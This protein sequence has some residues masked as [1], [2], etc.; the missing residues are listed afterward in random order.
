MTEHSFMLSLNN[1]R[2]QIQYIPLKRIFKV[3]VRFRWPLRDP[4]DPKPGNQHQS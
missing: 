4:S 1:E 3:D 2:L